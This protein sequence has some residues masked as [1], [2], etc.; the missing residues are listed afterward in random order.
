MEVLKVSSKSKLISC[1]HLQMPF[2]SDPLWKF[3]Q[4]CWFQI[5]QLKPLRLPVV[6]L[7]PEKI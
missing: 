6:M 5:R 1:R 2:V 4:W 7:P 3:K